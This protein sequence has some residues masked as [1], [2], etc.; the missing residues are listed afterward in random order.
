M[1]AD[2][3]LR[4]YEEH[5][6]VI[7][8]T[9]RSIMVDGHEVAYMELRGTVGGGPNAG[10]EYTARGAYCE[11]DFQE[12]VGWERK[13]GQ[14]YS[15]DG[16]RSCVRRKA[17]CHLRALELRAEY[18]EQYGDGWGLARHTKEIILDLIEKAKAGEWVGEDTNG[19]SF[20][21]GYFYLQTVA[22]ITGEFI[23]HLWGDVYELMA[24]KKIGLDGAVI[25]PYVEPPP[26]KWEEFSRIEDDGW[27]GIAKLP[28]HRKMASEWRFEV[29][30][31]DGESAYAMIPGE[32]LLH[33][34][35]VGPDVE[36]VARAEQRLLALIASAREG[37]PS[38]A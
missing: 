28:G 25:Q 15:L 12:G 34:P 22:A 14:M 18:E 4:Y 21:G 1:I 26:P 8:T 24:E 20:W 38:N 36:D 32:R 11:C 13:G 17:A 23:G 29:L 10:K 2:H 7:Y 6:G 37:E 3:L 31:P 35:V 30:R 27:V 5:P 9:L 33:D 16:E 19:A